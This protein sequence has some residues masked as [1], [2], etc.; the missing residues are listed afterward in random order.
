MT[1]RE[2]LRTEVLIVGGG[3]V[4]LTG[5]ALLSRAGM[6]N[7]VVERR[8]DT[9]RAPA[10]HV[11][12]PRTLEVFDR[13]GVGDEVRAAVP[14][15]DLDYITWCAT[16]GGT[17]VGRLDTRS[18]RLDWTNCPQNLLEPILLRRAERAAES[19]VLRGAEWTGLEQGPAALRA[20]VRLD[21]G[22]ERTIEAS[23]MIAADGA[24]SP[25]R[26]HLGIP[27]EGPGP[28]ARFFMVHFEAD[29]RPFL[30]GRSG[31]L[32]WIL[33]PAAPGTLI[34]HDPARSIVFMT[35]CF[36]TEGEAETVPARLAAALAVDVEPRILSVDTWAMHVQVARRYREGRVFLAGDAAHRFPPSGGLGLNTGV[37]DVDVL[38]DRLAR[39]H[40]PG[41]DLACLDSYERECRPCAR[42][43]A[44]ESFENLKRLG[45]I[46]R[47]IGP[48]ADLAA[49]EARLAALAPA[50]LER[51]GEAIEHQRSHFASNGRLP[52][53]PHPASAGSAR[54]PVPV[55]AAT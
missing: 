32:F 53:N 36:G 6:E 4:G 55:R 31:P 33:N 10:A 37:A 19:L 23:W 40:T 41:A 14:L 18:D 38:V 13:L 2:L 47:V 50:E 8:P 26:R 15:R 34:V 42:T 43:N 28:Q 51:L 39:A 20:R 30:E 24:G 27:M 7:V 9:I 16:L 21:D 52:A 17:E 12:R 44:T 11:L 35:P 1:G 3:P 49:L 46:S 45:E 22:T 5:S 25:V 48:C 54:P 29:L